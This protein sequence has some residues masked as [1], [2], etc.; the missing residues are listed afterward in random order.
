MGRA[1]AEPERTANARRFQVLGNVLR[2]RRE[3]QG[4]AASDL[5]SRVG[6][7]A[8]ALEAIECGEAD[9]QMSV[10]QA[11]AEHLNLTLHDVLREIQ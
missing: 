1:T 3:S 9:P 2:K 8:G 11:I 10:I 7:T 5:A 6:L 4:L